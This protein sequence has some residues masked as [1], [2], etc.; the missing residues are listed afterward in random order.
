MTSFCTRGR[1]VE[2]RDSLIDFQS[3]LPVDIRIIAPTTYTRLNL[4]NYCQ[5]LRVFSRLKTGRFDC[6]H[7]EIIE[8][9][10]RAVREVISKIVETDTVFNG[11]KNN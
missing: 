9:K 7:G 3:M 5:F 11:V 10:I 6:E 1:A 8:A 4:V 2:E